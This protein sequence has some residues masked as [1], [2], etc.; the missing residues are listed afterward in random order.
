M[1]RS[2]SP[3]PSKA[4]PRISCSAGVGRGTPGSKRC[5]VAGRRGVDSRMGTLASRRWASSRRWLR[6]TVAVMPTSQGRTATPS[7]SEPSEW[8]ARTKAAFVTSSAVTGSRVVRKALRKTT[9][10]WRRMSCSQARRSPAFVACTR[11]ASVVWPCPATCDRSPTPSP[12]PAASLS[13]Q[14]FRSARSDPSFLPTLPDRTWA[15]CRRAHVTSSRPRGR[16]ALSQ[17]RRNRS[18]EASAKPVVA[19]GTGAMTPP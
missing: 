5:W 17:A 10:W 16:C 15:I 14:T 19:S 3:M 2:S 4:P 18:E 1:S 9:S 13:S 7:L 6:A 8:W 11:V 12:M